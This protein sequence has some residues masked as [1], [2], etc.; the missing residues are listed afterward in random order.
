MIRKTIVAALLV[1]AAPLAAQGASAPAPAAQPGSAPAAAAADPAR[2]AAARRLFDQAIPAELVQQIVQAS[3]RASYEARRNDAEAARRDPHHAERIRLEE[4]VAGEEA[5]RILRDADSG[6]RQIFVES[7]ARGF[8]AADLDELGRFYSSP[9]GRRLAS[10]SI[11]IVSRP[12]YHRAMQA[13]D[14]LLERTTAGAEQ[15]F[16]A[17]MAHLPPIPG[18][19]SP[20]AL[21]AA[22]AA[23]A[24]NPAP[25]APA[26][27]TRAPARA[28]ADPARLAAARR[29]IDL[30]WPSETFRHQFNF[31]P[32][33]E[34]LAA[35][36][37]GDFGV[38]IP[39]SAGVNPNATL[40]D[41]AGNFDPHF[42]QR[43]PV[44][45]RFF[46]AEMARLTTAM[47]PEWKRIMAEEYARE[48]T[49]A[50]MDEVS[51]FAATPAGRRFAIDGLKL[52]E[53]PRF[54]RDLVMMIPRIAMQFPTVDQRIRQATAHLPPVP[55]EPAASSDEGG[56]ADAEHDED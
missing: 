4:R 36:R 13:L 19:P 34:T 39:P 29:A 14:P 28:P 41:I 38:P 21:A 47:E 22:G 46:G 6:M 40:Y 20:E 24:A 16:V 1:T 43:L 31:Q 5:M 54:V 12:E 55:P 3:V 23:R 42:R 11:A 49:V 48:F 18:M 33:A 37:V 51:R 15:R 45:T 35:M 50:E 10:G 44:L 7:F 17:A 25:A 27:A 9:A 30:L 8:S 32:A 2:L 56:E 52:V 53:D 26:P